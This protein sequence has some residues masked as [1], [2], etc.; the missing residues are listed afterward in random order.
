MPIGAILLCAAAT[1][2]AKQKGVP[3]GDVLQELNPCV[4]CSTASNNCKQSTVV[5]EEE[6]DPDLPANYYRDE[7]LRVSRSSSSSSSSSTATAASSS[8]VA[9]SIGSGGTVR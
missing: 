9:T 7:F 1:I 6:T 5:V 8:V 2:Y 4:A 3:L